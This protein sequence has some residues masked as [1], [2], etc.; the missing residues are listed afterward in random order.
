M[1]Q[2]DSIALRILRQRGTPPDG[3]TVLHADLG[4]FVADIARIGRDP[5]L[6]LLT[7]RALRQRS[8][9]RV[10]MDDLVWILRASRRRIREWLEHLSA[11]GV[12]VYDATN[13]TL[14][15]ELPELSPPTWTE[16]HPPQ[17]SIRHDLPTH[18]F[19]H[20]LP[21][22]GRG[23]FIAYLYLLHRDGTSA[24]ATLEIPMLARETRLRTILHARWALWR[25]RRAGL[26]ALA[27]AQETLVVTDPPPLTSAE[28]RA[29][30]RRR[31]FGRWTTWWTWLAVA[32]LALLVV[33]ALV[34]IHAAHPQ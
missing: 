13:G 31:K 21:R 9:G 4:A 34:A 30:R 22:I 1:P 11:A 33:L 5:A 8:S 15:V 17:L 2:L 18:W 26:V 7:I 20:V 27:A 19:I 23:A 24:P 6:L 32:T 29:L 12:L 3:I 14:D 25:L 16:V 10:F 28:R